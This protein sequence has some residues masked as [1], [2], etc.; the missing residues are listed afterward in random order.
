MK[1]LFQ[2]SGGALL[3]SLCAPLLIAKVQQRYGKLIRD[4]N[5]KAD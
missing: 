5:I 3:L 2:K 1:T 4:L